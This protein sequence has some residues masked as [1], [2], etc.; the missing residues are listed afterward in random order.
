MTASLMTS[1][2]SAK[3]DFL[4]P[5]PHSVTQPH[6][7]RKVLVHQGAAEVHPPAPAVV[8]SHTRNL[9]GIT[10]TISSVTPLVIAPTGLGED[11]DRYFNAH[12]FD[13]HSRLHI[14]YA[15]RCSPVIQ[16]FVS[17]LC[18]NGMAK[19]EAEWLWNF[20]CNL[21]IVI[22]TDLWTLYFV[23]TRY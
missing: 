8:I 4:P 3:I 22:T 14:M 18:K 5:F 9:M 2:K 6:A 19:S 11:I 13:T 16:D 17:Y 20:L 7:P 23:D 10:G 15:W 21:V 1:P 12:G